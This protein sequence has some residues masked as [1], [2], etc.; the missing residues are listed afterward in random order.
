MKRVLQL[1]S[2]GGEMCLINADKISSVCENVNAP[3]GVFIWFSD[4]HDDGC[5]IRFR[6]TIDQV[7]AKLLNIGVSL[8]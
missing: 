4:D 1:R 2:A 8:S 7:K 3:G 5:G 6:D